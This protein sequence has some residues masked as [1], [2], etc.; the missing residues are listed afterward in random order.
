[1][2]DSD[3]DTFGFAAQI[4][5][6]IAY[7]ARTRAYYKAIGYDTPY[8]WAHHT[9]APFQ[10]LRRPLARARVAIITTAMVFAKRVLFSFFPSSRKIFKAIT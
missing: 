6:P 8:R 2:A 5:E 7:M 10:P 9:G 3:S 4:D 1:M